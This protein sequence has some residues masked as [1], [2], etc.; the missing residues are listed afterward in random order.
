MEAGLY[1]RCN[2]ARQRSADAYLAR[3]IHQGRSCPAARASDRLGRWHP[4]DPSGHRR[5]RHIGVH[6]VRQWPG[7]C[8]EGTPAVVGGAIYQDNLYA[9]R[10]DC[11]KTDSTKIST[12]ASEDEGLKREQIWTPK[13]SA[14]RHRKN[15][16]RD[17]NT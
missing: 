7:V 12:V 17:Y 3:S 10:P 13:R 1:R 5:T 4:A 9:P 16:H 6:P 11:W 8:R 15:L 14:C 2:G